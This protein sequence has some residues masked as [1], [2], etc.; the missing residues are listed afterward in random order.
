MR[1]KKI[2]VKR[3]TEFEIYPKFMQAQHVAAI[4][5]ADNFDLRM[6]HA[7]CI[8]NQNGSVDIIIVYL[9]LII[10]KYVTESNTIE[11]IINMYIL[12]LSLYQI[13]QSDIY[14][15]LVRYHR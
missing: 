12:I 6:S 3:I 8:I 10:D 9:S 7:V 4:D 2:M 5:N 15:D 13:K 11:F 1:D 14:L